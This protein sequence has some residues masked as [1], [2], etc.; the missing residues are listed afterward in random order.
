MMN[1]PRIET[2]F[3]DAISGKDLKAE[4]DVL[5]FNV[6]KALGLFCFDGTHWHFANPMY[7]ASW[8]RRSGR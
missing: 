6:F 5:A 4:P 8:E 1:H 2:F 7:A 3:R